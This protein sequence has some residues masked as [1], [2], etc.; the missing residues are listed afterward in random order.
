[1]NSVKF[2]LILHFI[3]IVMLVSYYMSCVWCLLSC[4]VTGFFTVNETFNSNMYFWFFPAKVSYR[5]VYVAGFLC[6]VLIFVFFTRQNNLMKI[7]SYE[8]FWSECAHVLQHIFAAV[9]TATANGSVWFSAS[10]CRITLMELGC[11]DI[12]PYRCGVLVP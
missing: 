11:P 1:M 4:F 8:N 9:I 7:K 3:T 12:N 6:G 2:I 5:I 10:L